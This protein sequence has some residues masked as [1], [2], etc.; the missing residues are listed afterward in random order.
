M[1]LRVVDRSAIVVPGGPARLADVSAGPAPTV[2]VDHAP[3]WV[4]DLMMA[5]DHIGGREAMGRVFGA[6][7]ARGFAIG[8]RDLVLG[9][10]KELGRGEASRRVYLAGD[11]AGFAVTISRP[12]PVDH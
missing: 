2:R 8:W 12:R 9:Q 11:P 5:V 4:T 7:A 3:A 6:T 1:Q 10:I